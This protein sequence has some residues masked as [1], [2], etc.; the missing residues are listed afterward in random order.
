MNLE[1]VIQSE[2]SQKE[3]NN[4]RLLTHIYGIYKNGPLEKEMATHSSILA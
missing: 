3:K 1:F 2:L 4:Y